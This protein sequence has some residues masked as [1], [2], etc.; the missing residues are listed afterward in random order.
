MRIIFLLN[1]QYLAH[2]A[3]ARFMRPIPSVFSLSLP[4]SLSPSRLSAPTITAGL[5]PENVPVKF[6]HPHLTCLRTSDAMVSL[7]EEMDWQSRPYFLSKWHRAFVFE[8]IRLIVHY[9]HRTTIFPVHYGCDIF[10]LK[11][12][13]ECEIAIS[14][15]ISEIR[16]HERFCV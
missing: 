9:T 3:N 4:F 11:N 5:T 2:R 12:Y 14:A 8:N 16:T 13:S 15:K 10:E 1:A 7:I 6:P